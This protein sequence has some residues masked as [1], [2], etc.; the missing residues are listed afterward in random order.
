MLTEKPQ[1]IPTYSNENVILESVYYLDQPKF[2]LW[3]GEEF[4]IVDDYAT[5][6]GPIRPLRKGKLQEFPYRPYLITDEVLKHLNDSELTSEEA[7][8]RLKDVYADFVDVD[9]VYLTLEALSD[10][11]S[12][13]QHKTMTVPYFYMF[14]AKGSGKTNR[15]MVHNYL[16][17]RPMLSIDVTPANIYS[18]LGAHEEGAGTIIEDEFVTATGDTNED[19]IRMYLP[20]YKKGLTT[21]RLS[22]PQGARRQEFFNVFGV[23]WF[24]GRQLPTNDNFLDRCIVYPIYRGSP[25]KD[26]FKVEDESYFDNLRV[27]LLGWRMKTYFDPLPE[28][29]INIPGRLKELFKPLF[30]IGDGIGGVL[31]DL[32]YL[33]EL[34]Q[35]EKE[36]ELTSE[37]EYWI[38]NAV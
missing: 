3:D 11:L 20:G 32:L 19:K 34:H 22:F 28:L 30:R 15:C 7:F 13:Q 31:A 14:G 26:E 18:Y 12:Y 33:L 29:E 36:R 23:K 37:P 4:S 5:P 17:Y 21:A 1:P 6:T 25:K 16:A 8:K 24:T 38:V 2:L 27:L 9:D 35:E 10:M